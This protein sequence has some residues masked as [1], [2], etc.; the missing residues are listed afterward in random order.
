MTGHLTVLGGGVAGLA[1]GFYAVRAGIPVT[2]LEAG[3]RIGGLC[4]T[5]RR[6]GYLFDSGA[7]RFHGKDPEVTEDLRGLLGE[8]LRPVDRPSR[9]HDAGRLMTFPFGLP[10][11]VRHLGIGA[12]ARGAVE[13]ALARLLAGSA[14][15]SFEAVAVGRY[16]RTIADR[17]L[18]RY[19]EKLWGVP[20]GLL[21]ADATGGRL[22]GL[23]L[24]QF[25]L[26]TL[27][28]G[29]GDRRSTEGRF[30]YPSLGIG[31]IPEVLAEACGAGRVR[32]GSPVTRV[33]HDGR[34]VLAVEA[35]GETIEVDRAVSTIPL[36]ILLAVIDPPPPEPVLRLASRL[37]WR[38]LIL[39]AL[40]LEKEAAVDAATVYFPDPGIPFNR[41]TEPRNRS[42]LLA[43][44]GRTS[45]VAEIPGDPGRPPWTSRDGDLARTVL[46][47]LEGVGLVVVAQLIVSIHA[48]Y[49]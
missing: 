35:G 34:R 42:P 39:V 25:I 13:V 10:E 47:R 24:R 22:R 36:D 31:R 23:D 46:R 26:R 12:V 4:T 27:T 11:L 48:R 29:R 5:F 33:V 1:A 18:L 38:G 9:I 2:V 21:S 19:T 45:L 8:E 43:P 17:F 6:G 37:R 7:H 40:F 41:V 30:F 28:G 20:P 44:P 32:T 3:P 16:G 49:E 15:E 14:R